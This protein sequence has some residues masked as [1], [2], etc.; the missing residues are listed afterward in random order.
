VVLVNNSKRNAEQGSPAGRGG[1]TSQRHNVTGSP[2][3][4][5]GA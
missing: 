2:A 3:V 4:W 5:E 1:M